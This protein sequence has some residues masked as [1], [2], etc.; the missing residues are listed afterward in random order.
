MDSQSIQRPQTVTGDEPD[1]YA[2]EWGRSTLPHNVRTYLE[3]IE[4]NAN[5][6]L[7]LSE[8]L[9]AHVRGKC[10]EENNEGIKY[11]GLNER[12]AGAITDALDFISMSQVVDL[13]ELR[14]K[15]QEAT[16]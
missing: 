11:I 9:T 12:Q 2:H 15:T 1:M 14:E 8:M 16:P 3:R 10:D 7:V 5:V 6:V 13:Q 4:R